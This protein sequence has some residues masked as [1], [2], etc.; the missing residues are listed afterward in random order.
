MYANISLEK[1]ILLLLRI[2]LEWSLLYYYSQSCEF[3]D[4]WTN[5][6]PHFLFLKKISQHVKQRKT[7]QM[8]LWIS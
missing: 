6:S 8:K 1:P 7:C 5:D 4:P 2:V 3:N